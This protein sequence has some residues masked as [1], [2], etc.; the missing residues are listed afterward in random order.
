MHPTQRIPK[1]I[2]LVGLAG[3]RRA[4]TAMLG[5]LALAS[6]VCWVASARV[7]VRPAPFAWLVPT[8]APRDWTKVRLPSGAAVLSFPPDLQRVPSDPGSITAVQKNARGLFPI[9]LN[10]TPREGNEELATWPAFRV[11]LLSEDAARSSHEDGDVTNV[12]FLGG[13]GSCVLDDYF[14]RV[15]A[16]HYEE[17]ACY[18]KGRHGGSVVIA[19]TF[20]SMWAQKSA[21]LEQAIAAYRAL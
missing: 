7:E 17:I 19:S 1:P 8:K 3:W 10:A 15:G 6:M 4:L 14:S 21:L 16:H 18:V 12:P 5:A 20:A 9:Y 13:T 11:R 2:V